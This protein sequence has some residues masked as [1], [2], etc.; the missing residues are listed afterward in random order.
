M[1]LCSIEAYIT[2]KREN[3]DSIL[4]SKDVQ[5]RTALAIQ[6]FHQ[7]LRSINRLGT[8]ETT[9]G[10]FWQPWM[11]IPKKPPFCHV[12]IDDYEK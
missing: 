6:K 11:L 4:C 1:D 5:P 8:S 9:F 7:Y 12:E 3:H 10:N 2:N